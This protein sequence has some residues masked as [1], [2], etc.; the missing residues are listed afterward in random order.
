MNSKIG[1][2]DL[3]GTELRRDDNGNGRGGDGGENNDA[4]R[5]G[6]HNGDGGQH[7]WWRR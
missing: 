3:E 7:S 2:G 6:E 4:D 1:G 5:G